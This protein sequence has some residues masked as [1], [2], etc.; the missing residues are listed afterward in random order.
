KT[1]AVASRESELMTTRL[2]SLASITARAVASSR[3]AKRRT[4]P[5]YS[6]SLP[7]RDLSRDILLGQSR[8]ETRAVPRSRGPLPT[9]TWVA[10]CIRGPRYD[11]GHGRKR[12]GHLCDGPPVR[13]G[14][15]V[16]ALD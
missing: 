11:P 4:A 1:K 8:I 12:R 3:S 10:S 9:Q 2:S 13:L 14:L 15:M 16:S 7:N 6:A 5:S